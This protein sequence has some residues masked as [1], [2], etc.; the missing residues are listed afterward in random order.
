[1]DETT[2]KSTR[3]S[4]FSRLGTLTDEI[5]HR[6]IR[7]ELFKL[8]IELR[9]QSLI[10]RDDQRRLVQLLYHIRHG[11]CLARS[12]DAKKRLALVAFFEAFDKL[13]NR[14]GLIAGGGVF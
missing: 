13:F 6:V 9:R 12:G 14:L 5:L 11:K 4:S 10:V 3:Y 7:K 2:L 1:M 8:P